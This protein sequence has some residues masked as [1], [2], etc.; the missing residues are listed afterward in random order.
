VE[1]RHCLFARAWE[2]STQSQPTRPTVFQPSPLTH[3]HTQVR[4]TLSLL[5]VDLVPY[6]C[7]SAF[8]IIID[9]LIAF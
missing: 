8:L 5:S 3:F 1:P 2:G 7:P 4:L 9:R 6:I